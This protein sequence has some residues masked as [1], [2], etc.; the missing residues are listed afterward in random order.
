M[1]Y[2]KRILKRMRGHPREWGPQEHAK[3]AANLADLAPSQL[4][5]RSVQPLPS[6]WSPPLGA[7]PTLPFRVRAMAMLLAGCSGVKPRNLIGRPRVKVSHAYPALLLR[8]HFFS[9]FFSF[10]PFFPTSVGYANSPGSANPR[11]LGLEERPDAETHGGETGGGGHE[12]TGAGAA[13][14][15]GGGKGAGETR[16]GGN[17]GG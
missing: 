9:C 2:S 14:G 12:C 15:D 3:A 17:S 16:K 7:S 4:P 6:G 1:S 13:Q 10:F 5:V 8:T 11:I